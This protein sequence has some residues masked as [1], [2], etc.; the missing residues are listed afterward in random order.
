MYLASSTRK[1]TGTTGQGR[2]SWKKESLRCERDHI[3]QYWSPQV[4]NQV[5]GLAKVGVGFHF[6]VISTSVII[7]FSE[8]IDYETPLPL[9]RLHL[10]ASLVS[11]CHSEPLP[12]TT[13]RTLSLSLP[14][15]L[16]PGHLTFVCA[17]ALYHKTALSRGI[18]PSF[19]TLA[20]LILLLSL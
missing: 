14:L 20:S 1:A 12:P 16:D 18:T 11:I 4:C 2:S 9:A 7:R 6:C 3:A 10:P 15:S 13:S 8:E 5:T 19:L 17:D